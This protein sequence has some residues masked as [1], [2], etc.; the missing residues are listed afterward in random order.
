MKRVRVLLL[1]LMATLLGTT[2]LTRANATSLCV[3]ICQ[4]EEQNCFTECGSNLSCR[5]GCVRAET[6]C[7]IACNG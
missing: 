2:A 4:E 6:L 7:I 5:A 1:V 3:T